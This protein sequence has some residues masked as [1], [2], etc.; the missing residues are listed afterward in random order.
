MTDSLFSAVCPEKGVAAGTFLQ[1]RHK[2]VQWAEFTAQ[3]RGCR[4]IHCQQLSRVT[5]TS[6]DKE[7]PKLLQGLAL[8]QTLETNSG[9]VHQIT[10]CRKHAQA[11]QVQIGLLQILCFGYLTHRTIC[12]VCLASNKIKE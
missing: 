10:A 5:G 9:A 8:S 2:P 6:E 1:H 3:S 12:S 4:A 11:E 7:G